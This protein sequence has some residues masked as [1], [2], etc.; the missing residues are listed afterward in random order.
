M[1]PALTARLVADSAQPAVAWMARFAVL[2][3][4]RAE[5][6]QG[7][8]VGR[9]RPV[10]GRSPAERRAV[11]L[12]AERPAASAARAVLI[13]VRARA[14]AVANAVPAAVVAA[15][16]LSPGVAAAVLLAPVAEGVEAPHAPVVE[17]VARHAAAAV[18]AAWQPVAAAP[19]LRPEVFQARVFQVRGLAPAPVQAGSWSARRQMRCRI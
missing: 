17:A 2:S 1:R 4:A 14:Q 12:P 9:Y 7:G 5:L 15:A 19:V 10:G 16:L 3:V 13:V 18:P 11:L 8:S 6:A